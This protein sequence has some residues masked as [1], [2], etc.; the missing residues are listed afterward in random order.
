MATD[1]ARLIADRLKLAREELGMSLDE[2]ARSV[3]FNNYQ[4][5]SSIEKGERSVKV[6]ELVQ[7]ARIY[8]RS[9]DFFLVPEVSI[10]RPSVR[11]RSSGE[12][13]ARQKAERRFVHFCEEYARLEALSGH[14]PG[15]LPPLCARRVG[16]FAQAEELAETARRGME[17]GS[18]PALGLSEVL[19]ER[20]GVK[21]LITDTDGGGSAACTMGDYGAGILI[22]S[23]DAPW[24]RNYDIAH[25]LYHL[26]TWELN[27]ATGLD[28]A[29][30]AESKDEKFADCFASVLLLPMDVA[31]AEFK[32][33]VRSDGL[34]YTDLIM[35]AREFGVSTEALLW[36]L[37]ALRQVSRDA[38][39]AALET[40][41]LRQIDKAE[42]R[43]DWGE[44]AV[45]PSIRYVSLAYEC[46][47]TG[48]VSRGKFAELMGIRRGEI[49]EF[50]AGY[51]FDEAG[52]YT[53]QISAA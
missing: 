37:V 40:E 18:R 48:A 50:L 2:A 1:V 43:D 21:V 7:F 5:V 25:E 23:A 44:R 45:R 33:R 49:R 52:D 16:D 27:H 35:M 10:V 32:R 20:Y 6:A 26:L 24:R 36:R 28:A 38:A 51:G 34:A 11:W 4:T 29:A 8:A 3:G 9:L 31:R 22:N 12:A 30:D 17:L 14:Q 39:K 53:G 19:E 13:G 42:R 46:L 47:Q 41:K 15:A